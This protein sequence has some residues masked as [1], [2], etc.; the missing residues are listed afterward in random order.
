[1]IIIGEDEDSIPSVGRS[2]S[3]SRNKHRL[4]GI[5]EA[6]KVTADAFDGKGLA[7]SVSLNSVHLSEQSAFVSQRRKYPA[8]DHCGEASNVLTNDPSGP[9][10]VNSAEHL[11]PEV[12]RIVRASSLPCVGKRLAGEAAREDV[13]FSAPFAEVGFRDV[14]ITFAFGK[15]IVKHGTPEGVD[16]TMEGV[17]PAHHFR[18]HL[19][20]ADA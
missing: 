8:F 2:D 6:L 13:D 14:F 10:F 7:Q 1:M 5:S 19:R 20:A 12:T 3:R 4:D 16:F 9:D 15:P 11:R 17:A 18:S